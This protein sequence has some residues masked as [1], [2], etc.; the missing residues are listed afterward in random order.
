MIVCLDVKTVGGRAPDSNTM[1][2][3]DNHMKGT[4]VQSVSMIVSVEGT[5]MRAPVSLCQVSHQAG[6]YSKLAAC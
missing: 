1:S 3:Q 6:I 4:F 2:N 5:G